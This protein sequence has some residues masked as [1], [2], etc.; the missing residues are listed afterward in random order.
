MRF[1]EV[2]KDDIN[3]SYKKAKLQS[4]LDGF[5]ES[6]LDVAKVEW[7]GE[8]KS[9]EV[10]WASIVFAIKVYEYNTVVCF[11]RNGNVYLARVDAE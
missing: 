10:C 5:V 11:V 7:Q 1:V 9:A 6:G 8:Y 3:V 4:F 2:K